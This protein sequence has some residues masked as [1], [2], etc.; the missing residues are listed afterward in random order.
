MNHASAKLA[1]T[2]ARRRR[3]QARAHARKRLREVKARVLERERQARAVRR[4]YENLTRQLRAR[5]KRLSHCPLETTRQLVV[6]QRE[7]DDA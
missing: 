7:L 6:A 1:A 5:R 2:E 4:V 3:D